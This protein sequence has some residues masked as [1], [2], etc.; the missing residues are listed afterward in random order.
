MWKESMEPVI[1]VKTALVNV[2]VDIPK[3]EIDQCGAEDTGKDERDDEVGSSH[4]K[5]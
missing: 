3:E 1:K 4:G 2:T 5:F